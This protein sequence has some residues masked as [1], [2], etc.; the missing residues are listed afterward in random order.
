MARARPSR[1][2]PKRLRPP[3]PLFIFST[4]GRRQPVACRSPV[5]PQTPS[6]MVAVVVGVSWLVL[7]PLALAV[8]LA[9]AR[10]GKEADLALGFVEP[11]GMRTDRVPRN[12]SD[13]PRRTS[14][15]TRR[16]GRRQ[17]DPA[18][19]SDSGC[20]PSAGSAVE[21]QARAHPAVARS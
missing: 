11:P 17:T 6:M 13:A 8:M 15:S 21:R 18:V 1:A 3:V 5:G 20:L 2:A 14:W 19:T 7:C 16:G 12:G 4:C 10:A 9:L